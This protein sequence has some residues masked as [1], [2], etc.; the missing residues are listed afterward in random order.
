M[1]FLPV[2]VSF[3]NPFGDSTPPS[4]PTILTFITEERTLGGQKAW[5]YTAQL[6]STSIPLKLGKLL[7]TCV[8]SQYRGP[9]ITP[10][11]LRCCQVQRPCM[12]ISL[13]I[14]QKIFKQ[15]A[16]KR[17]DQGGCGVGVEA[18]SSHFTILRRCRFGFQQRQPCTSRVFLVRG[19]TGVGHFN[20]LVFSS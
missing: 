11:S 18:N 14:L 5:G 4:L 17:Q 20:A 8:F 6:S 7:T 10:A 1:L 9:A 19:Q 12:K 13:T 3:I 15:L 16:L 2:D